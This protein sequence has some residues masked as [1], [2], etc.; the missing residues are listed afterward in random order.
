MPDNPQLVFGHFRVA[1][2]TDGSP[3]ELGRGAMGVTYK[4]FDERLRIDVALKLITPAQIDN[5]KAQTSFLR[6]ARA[7]ARVHHSNVASVV[8]LNDTPGNFFYAMEFVEGQPMREWMRAHPSLPPLT[9]IGLAIQ[10]AR[11]LE[12][13]HEQEI[14]HR[15]LKPTNLMMV[16]ASRTA[17]AGHLRE[18]DPDAWRVKIIDFGLARAVVL[19]AGRGHADRRLSR[20]RALRESRAM[21]GAVRPRRPL[22]SLLAR[23]HHVG[24]ALRRAAFSRAHASRAAQPARLGAAADGS[25]GARAAQPGGGGGADA[26]Q[27]SRESFPDRGRLDQGAGKLPPENSRAARRW[28]RNRP[29]PR[30]IRRDSA[31]RSPR[32]QRRRRCRCRPRD[33]P[34]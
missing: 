14:V 29:P 33:R 15:D 28:S 12:A 24:D 5:P 26:D 9:V 13:I 8:F 2:H 10:I 21:R 3:V 19:R 11:G 32:G 17:G 31:R 22:G 16:R 23:L 7:A 18:Q 20:H 25:A 1:A 27:G 4:A 30:S 34:P 6:E